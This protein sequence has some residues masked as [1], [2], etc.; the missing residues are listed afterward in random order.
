MGAGVGRSWCCFS[1]DEAGVSSRGGDERKVERGQIRD[2][3]EVYSLT[4]WVNSTDVKPQGLL[5]RVLLLFYISI[6]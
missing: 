5:G 3:A 6:D 1:G 2:G 4:I